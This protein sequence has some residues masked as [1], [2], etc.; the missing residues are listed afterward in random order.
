MTKLSSINEIGN[1]NTESYD[2]S[3]SYVTLSW[4][5]ARRIDDTTWYTAAAADDDVILIDELKSLITRW[6]KVTS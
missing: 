6:K 3:S 5:C 2:D 1:Q 4:C